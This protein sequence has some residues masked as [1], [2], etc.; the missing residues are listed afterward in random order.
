MNY[1]D[2]FGISPEATPED[3]NT[4]H[5]ALAK[6]YH[7]DIY[8]GEDA[9]ERMAMLNEANAVLSDTIKREKYDNE[10]RRNRQQ[11]QSQ[12]ILSSQLAEVKRSRGMTEPQ[13][14]AEKAEML[15]RK[16][17]AR[18]KT[19]NAAQIRRK[20]R[21]QQ[22]S[23]EAARKNSQAKAELDKQSVI[24]GLSA[25][26]TSEDIKRHYEMEADE[27]RYYATKVLLS[28][29]RKDEKHLRR[30]AEEAERKQ[31]I[32]EILSLVKEYNNKEKWI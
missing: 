29:L 24:D 22:K 14:R 30:M 23:E 8:N 27:E 31:R 4:A 9:H 3:I 2:V 17:E 20:E 16:A 19:E 11:R 18:L 1:Y 15:R 10:L 7:P 21:A 12:V 5:K 28:L 25:L 6:M 13:E 32:E 26:V